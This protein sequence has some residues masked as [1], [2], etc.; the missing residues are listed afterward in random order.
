MQH[1]SSF[2]QEVSNCPA[3]LKW[4]TQ[5]SQVL[6]DL[7]R[8]NCSYEWKPSVK[9]ALFCVSCCL[10]LETV[11]SLSLQVIY[12]IEDESGRLKH[13]AEGE[14]YEMASVEA[15]KLLAIERNENKA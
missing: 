13:K 15:G 2:L 1:T 14:R 4:K 7:N 3:S 8:T 10:R 12:D 9:K 11:T 5:S 6:P